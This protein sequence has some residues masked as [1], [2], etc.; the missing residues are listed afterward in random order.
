MEKHS[1]L[2]LNFKPMHTSRILLLDQLELCSLML[3]QLAC[4]DSRILLYLHLSF[5][6]TKS[7]IEGRGRHRMCSMS[8]VIPFHSTI[9]FHLIKTPRNMLVDYKVRKL[10]SLCTLRFLAF[11]NVFTY[12]Y[13]VYVWAIPT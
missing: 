8:V 7:N 3:M 6:Q 9:P 10:Q 2:L 1:R 13:Y 12:N 5:S 4:H 11:C